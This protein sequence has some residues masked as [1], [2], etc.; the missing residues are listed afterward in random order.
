MA[1]VEW[2]GLV[3]SVDSFVPMLPLLSFEH[4]G[5]VPGEYPAAKGQFSIVCPLLI[6]I[7][8]NLRE[9]SVT[10]DGSYSE[11]CMLRDL[12]YS[13]MFNSRKWQKCRIFA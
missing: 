2:N 1:T 7:M 12:S 3:L 5:F 10:A 9:H 6:L 4:D 8:S 11:Y 13:F